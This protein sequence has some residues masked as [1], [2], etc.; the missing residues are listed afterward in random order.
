V[1]SRAEAELGVEIV[2]VKKSSA[3]YRPDVDPPCPSVK[4]GDRVLVR[5]G[6]V[7]F[8]QLQAALPPEQE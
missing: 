7:T 4:A 6:T 8:E 1:A 3:D 5:D 2:V